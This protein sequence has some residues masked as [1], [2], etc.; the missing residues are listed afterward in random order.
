MVQE[1]ICIYNIEKRHDKANTAK[2][3]SGKLVKGIKE[4]LVIF[5]QVVKFGK[6]ER[7]RVR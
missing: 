5:L 6:K 4:V 1:K 7:M 2:M 3:L